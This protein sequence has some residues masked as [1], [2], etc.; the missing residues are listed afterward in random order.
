[1]GNITEVTSC[2]KLFDVP[3]E[4]QGK[5]KICTASP[6]Q[7]SNFTVLCRHNSSL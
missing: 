7:S 3:L 2:D 6:H 5:I 4:E 1:M